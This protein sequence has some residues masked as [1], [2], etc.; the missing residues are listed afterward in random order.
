MMLLLLRKTS[1]DGRDRTMELLLAGRIHHLR[2]LLLLLMKLV[3]L[4]LL[5]LEAFVLR[6]L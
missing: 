5:Q 6:K 2:R 4:V 3:A 1:T